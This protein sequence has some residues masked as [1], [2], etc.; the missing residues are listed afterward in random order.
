MKKHEHITAFYLETLLL[1][2][3]FIAIILVLTRV[4]GMSRSLSGDA[5]LL[6]NAVCLAQNAAEAVSASESPEDVAVL[7]DQG[8]NV[9]AGDDGVAAYYDR[10]MNPGGA[11]D[12]ALRVEITWAP[13]GD[14]VSS[15]ISVYPDGGTA[16]VYALDTAVYLGEVSP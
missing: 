16:P 13:D 14:M 2:A 9:V 8:G 10:N 11:D 6:T 15:S 1:I 3:V 5:K 12:A 4:F 7:L